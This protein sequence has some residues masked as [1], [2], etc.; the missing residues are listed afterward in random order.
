MKKQ[1]LP[2]RQIRPTITLLTDST[3]IIEEALNDYVTSV[4]TTK[5]I[6]TP[7]GSFSIALS[8]TAYKKIPVTNRNLFELFRG[9]IQPGDLIAIGFNS[10][11]S[12]L[13]VVDTITSSRTAMNKSLTING[14]CFAS[15]FTDDFVWKPTANPTLEK[16]KDFINAHRAL[17]FYT[18]GTNW[19][20]EA[21]ISNKSPVELIK[22]IA[23]NFSTM[24]AN[25][26]VTNDNT[27]VIYDKNI[28]TLKDF[29][30]FDDIFAIPNDRVLE[31]QA[32]MTFGYG[33]PGS[34]WDMMKK[35]TD[36][37]FYELFVDYKPYT[38]KNGAEIYYNTDNDP[39]SG[40]YSTE[41]PHG[42]WLRHR[43][44]P[45]DRLDDVITTFSRDVFDDDA[46]IVGGSVIPDEN[47]DTCMYP[48]LKTIEGTI[49]SFTDNI[50]SKYQDFS[51]DNL[52]T[53][54]EG[55]PYHEILDENIIRR[56]YSRTRSQVYTIIGCSPRGLPFGN[57]PAMAGIL[58]EPWFDKKGILKYGVRPLTISAL[59][60]MTDFNGKYLDVKNYMPKIAMLSSRMKN[61]LR[62]SILFESGSVV[63][64]GDDTIRI[65]DRMY[66][67]DTESL[68]GKIGLMAY[69]EQV[70]N[71]WVIGGTY[72]TTIGF[73]RGINDCDLETFNDLESIDG[74]REMLKERGRLNF[75]NN[76]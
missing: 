71:S 65:G 70:S 11:F 49:G 33:S 1:I 58:R 31:T 74:L 75:G 16:H 62:P 8:P 2:A 34:V 24:N 61:W 12:F 68:T 23:Q 37:S 20:L 73:S 35:C 54:V 19:L 27:S 46:N 52:K 30:V 15:V 6:D 76:S 51:W 29:W 69:I 38:L 26:Y 50:N 45:F 72:T 28:R 4:T 64:P 55:K 9:H 14:R 39:N 21:Q 66:L 7:A 67:S 53:F 25:I 13:G 41:N 56:D 44:K 60:G 59:L 57:L 48:P 43:P 42:A 17:L 63:I 36:P 47:G 10:K 40:G 5:N 3:S 18:S 32:L 22:Y